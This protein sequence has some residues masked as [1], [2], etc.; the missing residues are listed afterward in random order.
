MFVVT[1]KNDGLVAAP[2]KTAVDG[3]D[4]DPINGLNVDP[5][6]LADKYHAVMFLLGN[7]LAFNATL[8]ILT[9]S[10]HLTSIQ[11]VGLSTEVSQPFLVLLKAT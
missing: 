4:C 1:S 5:L 3:D 9:A 7:A 8:Q 2:S 11:P 6:V 10:G